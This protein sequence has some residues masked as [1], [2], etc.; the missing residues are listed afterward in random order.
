[1]DTEALR[2]V[3]ED[4][5][6]STRTLE[7]TFDPMTSYEGPNYLNILRRPDFGL[8]DFSKT[9]AV[10]ITALA[11]AWQRGAVRQSPE[12]RITFQISLTDRFVRGEPLET[13]V[14]LMAEHLLE[15]RAIPTT[16]SDDT[17]P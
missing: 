2:A 12:D 13:F 10:Q 6:A 11:L 17:L 4:A 1:M 14:Q 16:T 8:L 3:V 15:A 5:M 7:I 9:Q